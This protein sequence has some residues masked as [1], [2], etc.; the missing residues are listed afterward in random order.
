MNFLERFRFKYRLV[1]YFNIDEQLRFLEMFKTYMSWGDIG[2]DEALAMVKENY[3]ATFGEDHIICEITSDLAVSV[4]TG[5]DFE[6]KVREYFHENIAVGFELLR[7]NTNATDSVKEILNLVETERRISKNSISTVMTGVLIFLAGIGMLCFVGG[8]LLPKIEKIVT[9]MPTSIEIQIAEG[10]FWFFTTMWWIYVP[11]LIASFIIFRHLQHNYTGSLRSSIEVWPFNLYK[12]FCGLRLLKLTG[13]LKQAG[14]S[15]A[16]AYST[17]AKYSSNYFKKH[18]NRYIK[19]F[20]TGKQR[21]DYFAS[22]LVDTGQ[23]VQLRMFFK[24]DDSVFSRGCIHVSKESET[25]I[26][27]ANEKVVKRWL[28]ILIF[29]G[30]GLFVLALGSA[31]DGFVAVMSKGNPG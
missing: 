7:I 17:I 1:T 9:N 18:L 19:H 6:S 25:A 27:M 5:I 10:S 4:R 3:A 8:V 14:L 12:T 21:E 13:L 16:E 15:D 23:M 30:L 28:W 24:H 31:V 26:E 29:A 20:S 11:L 22:G 2:F